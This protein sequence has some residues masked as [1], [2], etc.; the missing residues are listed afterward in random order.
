MLPIEPTL[1][2][3]SLRAFAPPL[4]AVPLPA[5]DRRTRRPC[6]LVLLVA[7]LLASACFRPAKAQFTGIWSADEIQTGQRVGLF[8]R[9]EGRTGLDGVLVELPMGWSL[10]SA[11]AVRGYE[12]IP[13]AVHRSEQV[14]TFAAEAPRRL[15]GAYDFVFQAETGGT[16]GDAVWSLIPYVRRPDAER[17]TRRDAFRMA[18][19]LRLVMPALSPE[20]RVLAFRNSPGGP[21]LLDPD[22]LPDLDPVVSSTVELWMRT[23]DTDEV[24]LSTWRGD[25]QAA[26]PLELVIDAAGRLRYFRGQPGQHLSM[27][28]KA[29]VADG[30]W[31]HV[32]VTHNADAGWTRLFLDGMATDSLF[33]PSPFQAAPSE[34]ALGGRPPDPR[35]APV[36]NGYTGLLD[37]VRFWPVARPVTTLRETMRQPLRAAAGAVVLGFE[38][39]P[40]SQFIAQASP[41]TERI[42]SDLVFYQPV[43]NLRAER[44]ADG[45]YLGWDTD[46]RNTR[47]FVVERSTDGR[48]FEPVARVTTDGFRRDGQVAFFSYLDPA[49]GE[50]VVFYRVRQ[51]FEGGAERVS[52]AIKLGLGPTQ[53]AALLVGNYPNPFN[54]TTTIGYEVRTAQRVRLSVWD[55]SGQIIATLI[56]RI[57]EPGYYEVRFDGSDLPSG[58]YFVR[59]QMPSGI[60]SRQ[61][62][63][64]K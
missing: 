38:E 23:T 24:V 36:S 49:P 2:T 52:A 10:R 34:V 45:V 37:E 46:D 42:T 19:R 4:D 43:R 51:Q 8:A 15:E 33:D 6:S 11:E 39:G 50:Q 47:A 61:M 60:Q 57:Q 5:P 62:I 1:P 58:T 7:C 30:Q 29:P 21:L 18:R 28:T 64:A 27:T 22:V 32:A 25:E 12:R 55:V 9:W 59:L 17:L 16:P 31:H 44:N 48:H 35:G 56:D 3:H 20:N 54:K 26:Y 41:R 13:L 53:E 14:Y 40:S 63:L